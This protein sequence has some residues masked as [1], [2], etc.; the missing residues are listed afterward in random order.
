MT[1]RLAYRQALGNRLKSFYVTGTLDAGSTDAQIVDADRT[2]PRD[3]WAGATI[4]LQTA[5]AQE[6]LVRA[7]SPAGGLIFLDT[8]LSD[9]PA[10]AVA[11]EI[12]KGWTITDFNDAIDW[13]FEQMFPTIFEPVDDLTTFAEIAETLEYTL[14]AAWREVN[15]V[16]EE[17]QGSSPKRWRKMTP[18]LEYE[19]MPSGVGFIL[20]LTTIDPVAGLDFR[21]VGRKVATIAATDAATSSLPISVVTEGALAFLYRKGLN[22]DQS[23]LSANFEKKAKEAMTFFEEGKRRY[24]TPRRP[25]TAYGPRFAVVNDG[26]TSEGGF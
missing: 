25:R 24:R 5:T 9:S 8:R 1:T 10:A 15:E 4:R 17:V 21:I 22:P 3:T 6:R 23:A 26:S 16:H 14:T 11:Y 13:A 12:V 7:G 19:L 2:E 18:G 20:R